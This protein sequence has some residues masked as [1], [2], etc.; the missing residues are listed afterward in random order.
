MTYERE[1]NSFIS[2]LDTELLRVCGNIETEVF[3][4]PTNAMI[5]TFIGRHLVLFSGN[6]F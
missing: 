4:E 2:F 3:K 1:N 6:A 5:Y